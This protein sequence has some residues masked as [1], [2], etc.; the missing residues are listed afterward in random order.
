MLDFAKAHV[1]AS[2]RTILVGNWASEGALVA[3]PHVI[4]IA[5]KERFRLTM[6]GK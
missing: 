6:R 3:V 5:M 1:G 2:Q 4:P